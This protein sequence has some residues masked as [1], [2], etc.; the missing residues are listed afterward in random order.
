MSRRSIDFSSPQVATELIAKL[1]DTTPVAYLILDTNL[2]THYVNDYY[3]RMRKLKREDVVGNYCYN[4]VGNGTACDNCSVRNA[5]ASGKR[6]LV[7]R[8][9]IHPDGSTTHID[10]YAIPIY[11]ADG[12]FDYILEILIDRTN[13]TLL[14]ESND[15]VFLGLIETLTSLLGKKDSYTS[16]HSRDVTS[17]CIKLAESLKMDEGELTS[18]RLAALLHDVGK[19]YIPDDIIN[20]TGGLT[21]EEFGIIRRHPLN[22]Y[23]MLK[24]LN[25]F[26]GIRDLIGG[27][28]ERWDGT[29]YPNGLRGE[30]IPLGA[31]IIAIADAYDAMTSTRSYREAISHEAAVAEILACAG[32]QFDPQL[33][34]HFVRLAETDYP[35]RDSLVTESASRVFRRGE[36]RASVE[37]KID[38]RQRSATRVVHERNIQKIMTDD[39]FGKAVMDNSP[40]YYLIIDDNFN[41][42]FASDNVAEGAGVSMEE[43]LTM[44]C[45]DISD[46]GMRCFGTNR[47]GRLRCPAVRARHSGHGEIGRIVHTFGGREIHCDVYAIPVTVH[48]VRGN[49]VSCIME[50][51]LDRTDEIRE[52]EAMRSDVKT[53]LDILL[54]LVANLDASTT[55]RFDDIIEECATFSDYLSTMSRIAN[56]MLG[57]ERFDEDAPTK[58]SL[59]SGSTHA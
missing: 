13:E 9:D 46:R 22:M 31:R 59:E 56:S 3:L 36:R 49:P 57:D 30:K 12:E 45:F 23:T 53:L 21:E 33:A 43:L 28:H 44:R 19:M 29:G 37:R 42:L 15:R 16:S 40:C 8:K 58:V 7:A 47:S 32:S 55:S 17:V 11:N 54:Q 20:K 24:E 50:I 38:S 10:D 14:R 51:L 6:E 5:I 1:V 41:L 26:A 2:R 35:S 25:Q 4:I 27:H 48:D 39:M 34:T 18:L 52:R